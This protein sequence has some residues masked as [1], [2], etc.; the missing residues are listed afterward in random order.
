M[1]SA[2]FWSSVNTDFVFGCCGILVD[3]GMS[4]SLIS[5]SV[6]D[7]IFYLGFLIYVLLF[8]RQ[9]DSDYI[10]EYVLLNERKPSQSA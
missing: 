7:W 10:D 5:L 4:V 6:W 1:S 3:M 8:S 9:N 2:F